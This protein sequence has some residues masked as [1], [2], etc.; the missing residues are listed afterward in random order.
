M[1]TTLELPDELMT[2]LKV[3][4][5]REN[6]RIKDVLAEALLRGLSPE[7]P[8]ETEARKTVRLPLVACA[9]E[10]RPGEELTPERVAAILLDEDTR[11][12]AP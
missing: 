2:A 8:A 1:K 6:R 11:A 12:A 5:A 3:R 9:H 4:A 10:A 7:V